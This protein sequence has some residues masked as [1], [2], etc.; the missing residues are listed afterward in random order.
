[1]PTAIDKDKLT[2][3]LKQLREKEHEKHTRL[4]ELGV[5][6]TERDLTADEL[7]EQKSLKADLDGLR[8]QL[9]AVERSLEVG[10]FSANIN[11]D[12][13]LSAKEKREYSLMKIVKAK[14]PHAPKADI[15]AAGLEFEASDAIADKLGVAPR[16]VYLPREIMGGGAAPAMT[17][18]H[19]QSVDVYSRG[20]ALVGVDF[21]PQDLIPLLRN[22]MVLTQLGA[23]Y[24]DGLQGDV[25]IPE[26]TEGGS[27]GWVS[28]EGGTLTET[29][30]AIGQIAMTPRTFGCYT[31]FTRQLAIQSSVGIEQFIRDDLTQ[32]MA[33]EMDRAA[34]HGTGA[35]GQPL[36]LT[37]VTGTNTFNIDPDGK[38]TRDDVIDMSKS[39]ALDNALVPDVAFVTEPNVYFEMMKVAVDTG[40][41]QFLLTE[42]G[43]TLGKRVIQ[44]NQIETN[45]LILGNWSD[46]LVG[47]WG[48]F[49]MLVDPLT[50]AKNTIT[51]LYFYQSCDIVVRRKESFCIGS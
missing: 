29:N 32:A 24:L 34:F 5:A 10:P 27:A 48:T 9:M 23:R 8:E 47:R 19:D 28:V 26:H 1:M 39:L 31:D 45:K 14:Q 22:K 42:G 40:S 49:E 50:Q 46:L 35:N 44:S 4:H 36:G 41:G 2:T 6:V 37:N 15:D 16:G 3:R 21:R 20:G 12:V 18:Q 11:D 25:L 7:T 51:R 17:A 30:Q 13:G 38:P 33:L 43:T